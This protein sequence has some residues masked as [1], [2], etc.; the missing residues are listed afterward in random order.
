MIQ[1]PPPALALAPAGGNTQQQPTS[2]WSPAVA[3]TAGPPSNPA[4]PCLADYFAPVPCF[5][6]IMAVKGIDALVTGF[7]FQER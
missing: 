4:S 3:A 6:D 1:K 2:L 5:S 7:S